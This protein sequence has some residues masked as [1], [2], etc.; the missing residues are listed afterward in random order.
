MRE[1]CLGITRMAAC[2]EAAGKLIEH[3]RLISLCRV[4]IRLGIKACFALGKTRLEMR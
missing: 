1:S 4:R 3:G 2:H